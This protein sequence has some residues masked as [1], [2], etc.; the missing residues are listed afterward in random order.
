[1]DLDKPINPMEKRSD[2]Y[3]KKKQ[4]ASNLDVGRRTDLNFNVSQLG[5]EEEVIEEGFKMIEEQS[6]ICT[7]S[8]GTSLD[9]VEN[10]DFQFL[11]FNPNKD[12]KEV[13]SLGNYCQ[14]NTNG[15]LE[16]KQLL[17]IVSP[18]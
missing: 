8:I 9:T 2:S 13:T 15:W 7:S 17:D 11:K 3:K 4:F 6:S 10:N 14:I 5:S 18:N 16:Q 12:H 1:M